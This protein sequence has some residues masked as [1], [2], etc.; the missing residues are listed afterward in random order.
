MMNAMS[1]LEKIRH[2]TNSSTKLTQYVLQPTRVKEGNEPSLLDYVFA[3]DENLIENVQ[4][5]VPLGKS[6]HVCVCWRLI[7]RKQSQPNFEEIFKR[8]L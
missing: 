3:N 1:Q 5:N 8:K 6:D 2:H 7:I 4:Y